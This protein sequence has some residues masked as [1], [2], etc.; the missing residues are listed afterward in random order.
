[1]DFVQIL[2]DNF[3]EIL[4]IIIAFIAFY[5][6]WRTAYRKYISVE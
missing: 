5:F 6:S 4:A 2:L 1:M 3:F